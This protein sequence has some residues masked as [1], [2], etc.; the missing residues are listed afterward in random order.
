MISFI[1]S[2]SK[3]DYA[4]NT[5]TLLTGSSSAYLIS[6]LMLP[7][8]SRL[9]SPEQ[10]GEFGIFLSIIGIMAVFMSGKFEL[11][12]INEPK[13]NRRIALATLAIMTSIIL[14]LLL[15]LLYIFL[16][17]INIFEFISVTPNI[18]FLLCLGL[19]AT[20]MHDSLMNFRISQEMVLP[21]AR[22]K[23][24]RVT[25]TSLVQVL[26]YFLES[27]KIGLLVGE[28]AGRIMAI[29]TVHDFNYT[30]M[31]KLR[32]SRKIAYLKL[33]AKRN[34]EYPFKIAPSWTLNNAS[35]LLLPVFLGWQFGLA[36][37]G[38]FFLMYKIFSLPET[39]IVQS[40][41]QSYM[42]ELKRH[43]GKPKKQLEIFQKTARTL[44]F[45]SLV[46]YFFLGLAFYFG[47]G[48][49]LGYDW[50][51]YALFGILMIP[52]FIAQFTMSSLYVSLNILGQHSYQ[53]MWDIFRSGGLCFLCVAVSFFEIHAFYFISILSMFTFI[54]YCLLFWLIHS[55]MTKSRS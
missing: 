19:L 43:I 50:E 42:V 17:S 25:A 39:A 36:V 55:V 2:L 54:S 23:V 10:F 45:L 27:S 48:F 24:A 41:N 30:K 38:G 28:V 34:L 47:V 40:V 22:A 15:V 44:F 31:T 12:I 52:Y 37:S 26:C 53:V 51:R 20:V 3:G 4:K 13:F 29:F 49:F 8:L 14:M 33:V 7:I 21:I 35:T 18:L 9:Y 46:I 11:A 6:A 1:R 5:I 16:V 32:I